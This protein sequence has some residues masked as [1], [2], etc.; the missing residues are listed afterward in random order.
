MP[1]R[2]CSIDGCG[3]PLKARGWCNV[4]HMRY[5]RHGDPLNYPDGKPIW[6]RKGHAPG[7]RADQP[8]MYPSRTPGEVIEQIYRH[9]VRSGPDQCWLWTGRV[10]DSGYPLRVRIEGKYFTRH[11][12]CYELL[13]GEIPDGLLIDHRCRERRCLNP[14]HLRPV[15]SKQNQ[16][17]QG[18]AD[19]TSVSGFRNVQWNTRLNKWIVKVVHNGHSH[20]GG[21]FSSPREADAVAT[22]MRNLL[23]THNDADRVA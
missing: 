10:T 21:S 7:P 5:L 4:H 8:Q 11:R 12:L 23:Y 1:D 13:I 9:A 3:K 15:T 18:G 6:T 20:Y 17:N 19:V 22:A 2:T 14:A 16:E